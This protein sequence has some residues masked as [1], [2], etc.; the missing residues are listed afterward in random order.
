MMIPLLL[1]LNK[2]PIRSVTQSLSQ[3]VSQLLISQSISQS[4]SYLVSQSAAQSLAHSVKSALLYPYLPTHTYPPSPFLSASYTYLHTF[5]P[6][7]SSYPVVVSISP[8]IQSVKK[9]QMSWSIPR[10]VQ[11]LSPTSW[12]SVDWLE[13]RQVGYSR[14]CQAYQASLVRQERL[15]VLVSTSPKSG[16]LRPHIYRSL[17]LRLSFPIYLSTYFQVAW[18]GHP[19]TTGIPGTIDYFL[20]SDVEVGRQV[21]RQVGRQIGRQVGR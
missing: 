11:S 7:W 18:W 20:S 16:R 12:P 14:L 2:V 6:R 19:D 1:I 9:D 8:R 3:L 13:Y 5:L 4:L 17:S 21:S 10:L 15:D